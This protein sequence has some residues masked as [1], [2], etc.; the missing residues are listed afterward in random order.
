MKQ[1]KYP[2]LYILLLFVAACEKDTLPMN[3][4]PALTTGAASD[5]YRVGATLSGS[6][7]KSDGVVV[8]D[9]GILISE[10]QSMAEYTEIKTASTENTFDVMAQN[11][12]P[13][14]KY[15]YCAYASSGYSIARGEIRE[16]TTTDSNAP[17]FSELDVNNKDEKSFTVATTILDE[18]GSELILCG[19]CW[20]L[21]ES[22]S[23]EPTVEDNVSNVSAQS[24]DISTRI[25]DL[26][27]NKNYLVRA[28]GINGRGVGYGKTITVST[29]NATVP[30]VSSIHPADSTSLSV[31]VKASILSAG[32]SSI[33]EIGFCWSAESKEPTTAH[34]KYNATDQ[35]GQ[36]EFN[37]KIA[38]LKPETTYYIRA[39]AI[40]GQGTGYGDT[41]TYT[42]G[43]GIKV[44]TL[45]VDVNG[46]NI[47]AYGQVTPGTQNYHHGFEVATNKDELLN[48]GNN[49]IREDIHTN[50]SY[51]EAD[52]TFNGDIA[53][54]KVNTT[55][56]IRAWFI[57]S[58]TQSVVFG[59]VLEF[60][61]EDAPGIYS[62][63][64]LIDFRDA[65]NAKMNLSKWKDSNGVINVYTDIDLTSVPVWAAIEELSAGE[66]FEGNGHEITN[67]KKL[68][69]ANPI[70]IGFF[71]N[72]GGT[73]R[74][75]K[76]S[77]NLDV[78]GS[79][80]QYGTFCHW[81]TGT[82]YNCVNNANVSGDGADV[83]IGGICYM[84]RNNATTSIIE[85]CTNNGSLKSPSG[86]VAGI[87]VYNDRGNVKDCINKGSIETPLAEGIRA[88]SGGVVTYS[89]G[90]IQGCLNY[91]KVAGTDAG[92]ISTFIGAHSIINSI[93]YGDV[94]GLIAGGIVGSASYGLNFFSLEIS[95]NQN[96]GNIVGDIAGGICGQVIDADENLVI[97]NNE[98]GGTVNEVVGTEAN[99]IGQNIIK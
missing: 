43:K 42:T 98:T 19:F 6:I 94:H 54:L 90:S 28:Y 52:G 88:V 77:G 26:T 8:K 60:E 41:Y 29:N 1:L 16:F 37:T 38:D 70:T 97:S 56:Y 30:A 73:I 82:I 96:A 74:N 71:I 5:I 48:G 49:V 33:S 80:I 91:G 69:A 40:N 59:N 86:W 47:K 11:L 72:N 58:T 66:I 92:G 34:L 13:G 55:Y 31:S 12:E 61:T 4:S 68:T 50:M 17:V 79:F 76:I 7:Q 67:L 24:K 95:G 21:S 2:I 9:C 35:L 84:V 89:Y 14:K 87:V 93:N 27:P 64:D 18:G 83:N 15:Y 57:D 85:K 10:L 36:A 32:E 51:N 20:K 63:Q 22:G 78:S 25:K 39:Y 46:T 99:A 75:L 44:E 62:L 23:A 81:N 65:K 3:F 45:K 53:N